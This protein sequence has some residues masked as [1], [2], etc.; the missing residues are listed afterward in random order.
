MEGR[1]WCGAVLVHV[2]PV[3]GVE[4]AA[5]GASKPALV[6]LFGFP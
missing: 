6:H 2:R 4:L 5:I 3:W 1:A